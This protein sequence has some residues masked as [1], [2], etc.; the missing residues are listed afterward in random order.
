MNIKDKE[1][2][3]HNTK[4]IYNYENQNIYD[5]N[6]VTM[7]IIKINILQWVFW[8]CYV[9]VLDNVSLAAFSVGMVSLDS[10][11]DG[12]KVVGSVCSLNSDEGSS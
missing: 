4:L 7:S 9:Q 3:S 1:S 8:L 10:S 12:G 5:Y 6:I 2:I 11:F